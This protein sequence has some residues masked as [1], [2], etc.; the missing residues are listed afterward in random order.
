MKHPEV[1]QKYCALRR[2]FNSFLSASSGDETLRLML[3]ILLHKVNTHTKT[4]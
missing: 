4:E 2:I 1:R 3:N